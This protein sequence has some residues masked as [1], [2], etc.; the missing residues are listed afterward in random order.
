M[1][2]K[3]ARPALAGANT[4]QRKRNIVVKDDPASFGDP[5][6]DQFIELNGDLEATANALL[7][8]G[9]LDFSR[10]GPVLFEILLCGSR[11]APGG[12][13]PDGENQPYFLLAQPAEVDAQMPYLKFVQLVVRRNP[14]LIQN[15][16]TVLRRL[17]QALEFYDEPAVLKLALLTAL[18]FGQKMS[19][20][21]ENVFNSLRNEHLIGKGT[22]LKFI[23]LLFQQYLTLK[24]AT[25]DDLV[26]VLKRARVED[27]LLEFFP[28]NKRT[29]QDFAA[30]F[31]SVGMP[32]LVAWQNTRVFDI[33]LDEM[34]AAISEIIKEGGNAAAIQQ[35]IKLKRKEAVI[36]DAV[37]LK[38]LWDSA[39]N[40]F[41]WSTKNQNQNVNNARRV[42]KQIAP[43]L[44][45]FAKTGDLE[46]Q[47]MYDIQTHCFE[48]PK[49]Q[50]LFVD[51]MKILYNSDVLSEKTILLWYTKGKNPKGRSI[52]VA[53]MEPF[54]K[55]LEEAS[56]DDGEES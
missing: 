52:F 43:A 3:E 49:M 33:V 38:T 17:L 2:T 40:S 30:H 54:I 16:E 11:L 20:Q 15:F 29:P 41:P 42:I 31:N 56:E 18:C 47:L 51:V 28:M 53:D 44:E 23:T 8:Q 35:Q 12:V 5:V 36:E 25:L 39:I 4:K 21:P 48:D 1:T 27:G 34:S 22:V 46:L 50:K 19:V 13:K 45:P 37:I 9:D 32:E 10:Y 55:W 7:A 24:G 14:F 6:I 26:C